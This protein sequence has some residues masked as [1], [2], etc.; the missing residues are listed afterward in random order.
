M[1]FR[2]FYKISFVFIGY[3]P[4]TELFRD[5]IDCDEKGYFLAGDDTQTKIPGVFVAGD[6]RQKPVRQVVTATSDGAVAAVMAE[7]Y[8]ASKFD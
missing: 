7:R 8:I 5:V 1:L 2:S 6:C 3:V 4:Q